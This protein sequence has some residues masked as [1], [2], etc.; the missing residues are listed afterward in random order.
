MTTKNSIA[1][2]CHT[3]GRGIV[4]D[5]EEHDHSACDED[6]EDNW[7]CCE[8]FDDFIV[9][10]ERRRCIDCD[11]DVRTKEAFWGCEICGLNTCEECC[12]NDDG[13]VRCAGCVEKEDTPKQQAPKCLTDGCECEAAKNK[14]YPNSEGGEFWTL[15]EKCYEEDQEEE[16]HKK[17]KKKKKRKRLVIVDKLCKSTPCQL[18]KDKEWDIKCSMCD[19]YYKDDGLHDILDVNDDKNRSCKLCGNSDN[20]VIMKGTG[21]CICAGRCY[22][23]E[24]DLC[25]CD[26]CGEELDDDQSFGR[27]YGSV[28]MT[29][30]KECYDNR[31]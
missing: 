16:T 22:A 11:D 30:C 12:D 29:F 4:R 26:V 3:C 17:K 9:K 14:Y 5:S 2:D 27:L 7:Y 20:V 25:E 8:C 1:F 10:K 28:S 6:N 15:C 21:S 19:G 24:D 13:Y 18:I 23:D 31:L